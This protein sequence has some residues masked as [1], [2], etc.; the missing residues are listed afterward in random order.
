MQLD[1]T[2]GLI[3]LEVHYAA[4]LPDNKVGKPYWVVQ[5]QVT[6]QRQTYSGNA[7]QE[8]MV[9]WDAPRTFIIPAYE[10]TLETLLALG[11]QLL[12]NPPT[13]QDGRSAAFAPV[14]FSAQDARALA[15]FIVVALEAGRRDML[16]EIQFELELSAPL[17]WVLPE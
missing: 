15:E 13:L 1:P 14:T 16:R 3:A 4:G 2:S 11:S 17:L 6:L 10:C 8:A 5:G 9:F 12:L 7:A